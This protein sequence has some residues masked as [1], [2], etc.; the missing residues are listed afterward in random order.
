MKIFFDVAQ[1]SHR[2]IS[3]LAAICR[4]SCPTERLIG[5]F[6]LDVD[7]EISSSDVIIRAIG[8]Q[9]LKV[10][11]SAITSIENIS[12]N[13]SKAFQP[14]RVTWIEKGT[15]YDV[16]GAQWKELEQGKT[17]Q[18]GTYTLGFAIQVPNWLPATGE[19][20]LAKAYY[21]IR[22]SIV[23]KISKWYGSQEIEEHASRELF[24]SSH[25]SSEG[26]EALNPLDVRLI[27]SQ[28]PD[29]PG[30][31][32]EAAARSKN[33]RYGGCFDL[34]G[35]V[36]LPRG[37]ELSEVQVECQVQLSQKWAMV[38]SENARTLTGIDQIVFLKERL[39]S[40]EIEQSTPTT[41]IPID[42]TPSYD[43][44]F[45]NGIHTGSSTPIN[46]DTPKQSTDL[47]HSTVSSLQ[48]STT[49]TTQA[50][51]GSST[52]NQ[53]SFFKNIAFPDQAEPENT[54]SEADEGFYPSTLTFTKVSVVF[55]HILSC[56]VIL[57]LADNTRQEVLLDGDIR[58]VGRD[59]ATDS[60]V[61]PPY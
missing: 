55:S 51:N 3:T 2:G 10:K 23:G 49:T 37:T 8:L 52:R 21:E 5:Y 1:P 40:S 45:P 36:Q 19:S 58:L 56:K 12:E 42:L 16:S 6:R 39:P 25:P 54:S 30:L 20:W 4:S 32:V 15:V 14:P 47:S 11:Y 26:L 57:T 44:A 24:V 59:L 35:T 9:S 38:L 46:G 33:A 41:T 27:P 22:A 18:P 61:A 31:K 17:F 29:I 34:H 43:S 48:K 7:R 53:Y 60:L 50:I 28:I 13:L